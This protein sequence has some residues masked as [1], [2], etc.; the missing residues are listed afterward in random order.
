M[1]E[2]EGKKRKEDEGEREQEDSFIGCANMWVLRT[3]INRDTP[4]KHRDRETH[5]RL[6]HRQRDRQRDRQ[7][8]IERERQR[9]RRAERQTDRQNVWV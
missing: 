3:K 6:Q 4:T 8:E 1:D 5:A 9:D 7:A 2:N